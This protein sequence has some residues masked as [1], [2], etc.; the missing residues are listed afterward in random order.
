[1]MS[2]AAAGLVAAEASVPSSMPASTR[3]EIL[4]GQAQ[5]SIGRQLTHVRVN[6]EVKPGFF[7]EVAGSEARSF[8]GLIQNGDQLRLVGMKELESAGEKRIVEVSAPFTWEILENV[9]PDLGPIDITLAETVEGT[10]AVKSVLIG[11]KHYMALNHI[12]TRNR[13][14]LPP[15]SSLYPPFERLSP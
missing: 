9:A 15:E 10:S 1:M 5:L 12:L 3:E 6:F 13:A 14:F 7:R 2:D 4:A 11:K 8:S